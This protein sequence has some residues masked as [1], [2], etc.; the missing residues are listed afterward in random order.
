MVTLSARLISPLSHV[1]QRWRESS[2][3]VH[4]LS[5]ALFSDR[6]LPPTFFSVSN[7]EFSPL[8]P[9]VLRGSQSPSCLCPRESVLVLWHSKV[10]HPFTPV[11]Y[12]PTVCT[13]LVLIS[14]FY[15]PIHQFFWLNVLRGLC[16]L[17]SVKIL[18]IPRDFYLCLYLNLSLG[19]LPLNVIDVSGLSYSCGRSPRL[20]WLRSSPLLFRFRHVPS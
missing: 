2:L 4:W 5:P 12:F 3:S 11:P 20:P 15:L 9:G 18:S 7:V 1:S 10:L 19:S 6:L 13:L 14:F 16:L 17:F 8:F